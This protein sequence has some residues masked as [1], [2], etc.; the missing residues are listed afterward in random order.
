M[1]EFKKRNS[2]RAQGDCPVMVTAYGRKDEPAVVH[3]QLK[4]HSELMRESGWR[5][6]DAA[7]VSFEDDT[8]TLIRTL[9]RSEGFMVTRPHKG[10][11]AGAIKIT[12]DRR[13]LGEL[14]LSVRQPRRCIV[15]D[16]SEQRITVRYEF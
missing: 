11:P 9:N 12:A 10:S 14:G 13:T 4:L 15:L 3:L 1:I 5:H 16:K 8:W 2:G 7:V 6:G